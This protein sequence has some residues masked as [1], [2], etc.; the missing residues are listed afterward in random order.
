MVEAGDYM[1][2][3]SVN[4]HKPEVTLSMD[5]IGEHLLILRARVASPRRPKSKSTSSCWRQKRNVLCRSTSHELFKGRINF[6]EIVRKI[7]HF[8]EG[9]RWILRD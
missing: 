7:K 9:V 2:Y 8:V 3:F 1:T 6:F 4:D 5:W